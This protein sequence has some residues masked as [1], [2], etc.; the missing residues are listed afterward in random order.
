LGRM[1]VQDLKSKVRQQILCCTRG[2]SYLDS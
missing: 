2:P 1:N